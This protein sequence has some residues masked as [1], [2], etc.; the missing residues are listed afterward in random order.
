M[1]SEVSVSLDW[2]ERT[3]SREGRPCIAKT[4]SSGTM[5]EEGMGRVSGFIEE[6]R[7]DSALDTK[8]VP[9]W[10]MQE[11]EARASQSKLWDT[12]LVS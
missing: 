1:M 6:E 11:V 10:R 2:R 5:S 8:D 3:S 4:L 9:R 12:S 7:G